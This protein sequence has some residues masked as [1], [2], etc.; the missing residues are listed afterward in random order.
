[1]RAASS[2][3]RP[4]RRAL[5]A[6]E[7]SATRGHVVALSRVAEALSG[8][9]ECHAALGSL[10]HADELAPHCVEVIQ[11]ARLLIDYRRRPGGSREPARSYADVLG[12][13]GFGETETVAARVDWWIR[14]FRARRITLLVADL[15][16]CALLAARTIGMPCVAMGVGFALPPPGLER[17]PRFF[18][19]LPEPHHAE[20]RLLAALARVAVPGFPAPE[21][22]PEVFA[23]D[24]QV[25]KSIRAI[26]PYAEARH[27]AAL[28]QINRLGGLRAGGGD[29]VFVYFSHRAALKPAV[30][31]AL[32]R[33]SRPVRAYIPDL[34]RAVAE[35][36]DAAGVILEP[37]AVSHARIAARSRLLLGTGQAG[38]TML[39]LA[40][41]LPS[42]AI[43]LNQ[44]Q[45]S[46]A[47]RAAALGTVRPLDRDMLDSDG[48]IAAV[49]EMC[50]AAVARR[51]VQVAEAL[52]P[53]TE[54]DFGALFR[55]RIAGI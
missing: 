5:L 36:L 15:A 46:N 1:M 39:A 55:E 50:D 51:A 37:A 49:E 34:P 26:D 24:R 30:V 14:L 12:D 32:T 41:G 13:F 17:F 21:R 44:E 27:E 40:A 18:P 54:G 28:P 25:V 52:K 9:F 31:E 29:E 2:R 8:R 38:I 42:V 11:G 7:S 47:I 48:L 10:A 23:A 33:I 22:L 19:D 3:V 20:E 43:P 53:E 6:W 35:R 4:L 16:P 45:R